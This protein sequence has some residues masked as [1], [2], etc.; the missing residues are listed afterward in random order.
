MNRADALIEELRKADAGRLTVYLGAAPGV[1]KTYA[2]LS[3]AQELLKRGESIVVGVIETHGRSATQA[4]VEGLPSIAPKLIE[5]RGRQV[6]EFNLDEALSLKPK[7]ILIDELA[8]RNAPGSQFQYRWQDVEALLNAGIDV[9]TTV[10]V[11]HLESLNDVILQITG[12]RVQETVPDSIFAGL[13]DIR[14]IDLPPSEL[15]ERLNQGQ[16]YVKDLA[17][18]ALDSFFTPSNLTA[19]RELA[20]DTVA[21]YVDQDYRHTRSAHGLDPLPLRKHVLIAVDHLGQ[22]EYLLR[23]GSRLAERRGATWSAIAVMSGADAQDVD[24]QIELDQLGVL[25]RKLGG[26]LEWVYHT[27]VVHAVLDAAE[28]C[29]AHAILIGRGR[30]HPLAR[31]LNTTV[32]QQLIKRGA[33]YEITLV[34]QSAKPKD[35]NRPK[36][37]DWTAELSWVS[38]LASGGATALAVMLAWFAESVWG[39]TDLSALFLLAV[40]FVAAKAGRS[41]A[42]ATAVLCFLA[43][44]YFFIHPRFTFEIS[45]Q[46]GLITVLV[47]LATGLIAGGLAA[48][49]KSQ[50]I[51]LTASNQHARTIQDLSRQLATAAD[52]HQVLHVGA[53]AMAKVLGAEVWIRA[54]HLAQTPMPSAGLDE[55]SRLAADWTEENREECGR[56]THTLRASEWW[57]L[58]LPM[59]KRKGTGVVGIKPPSEWK[60]PTAQHRRLL[61]ALISDIGEAALRTCLVNELESARV[62]S[63]T[64]KLR[65]ALLSSVSHD[66]RSPLSVM[67]GSAESLQSFDAVLSPQDKSELLHTIRAEG[68]RLDRYIQNLLDMTRLGHQGLSLNREWVSAEELLGSATQRLKRYASQSKFTFDLQHPLPEL[69]VHPALIEQALFNVLENASKFS[70]PGEPISIRVFTSGEQL[71]IDIE[72]HGPGIPE[73]ERLQVFDMFYTMSRGDRGRSGTG[74]GLTIVQ[75]IVGSHMGTV[76]ALPCTGTTGTR[77]RMTLPVM[78]Q[79]TPREPH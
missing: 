46:Q 2:M 78:P 56:F 19:L 51:A 33:K 24:Q 61:L 42:M 10:N 27:D 75:G 6:P 28:A 25:A 77:I 71:I 62:S 60:S 50:V 39:F 48:A 65:S 79:T 7:T 29:H 47:F 26:E 66:L 22:S 4:L 16:V 70:P 76:E 40:V 32:S 15:I 17:L 64:E 58:P 57:F 8:H 5:H 53:K 45:A 1:G 18:Q 13:R 43:Y 21:K 67:I 9:H 59:G 72:D 44:N 36:H 11:Q 12:I 20:M 55:K 68:Q 31:L 35:S 74:L 38:I 14:L 23:A 41:A 49:L 73:E 30:E 37:G 63:E 54:G 69:H 52:L 34:G 3:R